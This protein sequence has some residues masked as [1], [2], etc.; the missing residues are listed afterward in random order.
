MTHW[1]NISYQ[2][3]KD[4]KFANENVIVNFENG[5]V[6][7]IP[8]KNLIPTR[9]T[10]IDWSKLNFSSFEI[11]I[12]AKPYNLEIP[13]DK[14]RVISDKDFGK[15]LGKESEEQ[16]KLIGIKIKR[17][18]EKKGIKSSELAERA[19]VTPQTISRIEK[20]HTDVGFSTLRKILASIGYSLKD[21][22]N[23]ENELELENTSKSFNLLK[24][25]LNFTGIDTN[26]L[27]KKIIP[28][29]LQVALESHRMSQPSLLLDEAA[30]YVSKIFGWSLDEIWTNQN[31]I[32]G[33]HPAAMAYFKNPSKANENQIKAYSHYAYYL[34]KLVL[35]ASPPKSEYIY[36]ESLD[37]F[38]L[39]YLDKYEKIELESLLVFAWE[40]GICVLPLND[41][42]VFHGAAWNIDGRH[43]IVLKQNTSAHARWIFDLL[44]ELYHV[45]AHLEKENTSVVEVEELN[46]FSNTESIEELEANSFANQFIFGNE[47]EKLAEESVELANWKIENLKRTVLKVAKKGKIREDFLANYLAFRL[48]YQSENWWGTATKM[49]ITEPDPFTTAVNLLKKK[50]HLQKL[51]HMDFNLL[52]TAIKI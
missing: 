17:L 32:L 22:A 26:L 31:L 38:K 30:S 25:K 24:Q 49:Q 15:Y 1:N 4:A 46:P 16:S 41:S 50:V 18:R 8:T 51:G 27:I 9:L 28:P 40:L 11:T 42:G 47:A 13:W 34:A 45:F 19:G 48:S 37:E 29:K 7:K 2:K 35:K 44:H 33:S 43:I 6:I 14:L 12:P 20:G 3:I 5:D 36:P 21:L 10:N 39:Q 23:E 52:S